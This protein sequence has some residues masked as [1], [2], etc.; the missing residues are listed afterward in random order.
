MK[1]FS[2]HVSC[3][4]RRTAALWS[5]TAAVALAGCARTVASEDLAGFGKAAQDISTQSDLAFSASN[6][7]ARD[8]SIDRFVRSGAVG[9]S[10][11]QFQTAI[12]TESIDAW[13]ESLSALSDY[14]TVLS[15]LVDTKRGTETS[16]AVVALGQKLQTGTVGIRINP[17]V[18]TAF[19]SLGGALVDARAQRQAGRILQQTDPSVQ[20]LLATMAEAIGDSNAEG[21]RGTVFSNWNTSFDGV[22]RAYA[23]A[24]TQHREQ[25]QRKLIGEYLGA[26]DRRDAQLR[27]L[28]NL[29]ASIMNLAAAHSAAAKGAPVTV[30]TLIAQIEQRVHETKRIYAAVAANSADRKGK[31]D[32]K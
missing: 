6:K 9:L 8:V 7:L 19:A 15:S 26:L 28:A 31:T 25:E 5:L 27:A 12:S 13:Q 21:L 3:T 10:E 17:A 18:S 4:R 30:S 14:G 29:R 22:R 20:Q 23:T 1:T 32:A 16:A 11:Q 24:A 2:T